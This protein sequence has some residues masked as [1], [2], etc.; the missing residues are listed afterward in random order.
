MIFKDY[1]SEQVGGMECA[2][3]CNE[4]GDLTIAPLA[5]APLLHI[6]TPYTLQTHK[7]THIVNH[8]LNLTAVYHHF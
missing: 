1:H 8:T 7:L 4:C 6:S 3:G 2:K 5:P